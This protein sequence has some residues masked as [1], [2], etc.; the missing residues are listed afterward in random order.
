MSILKENKQL[1]I[2][3]IAN[4]YGG[5]EVYTNLIKSLDHLGVKQTIFVPLNPKNQNRIGNHMV[6]FSV[7]GSSIIYSTILKTYHRYFYT[8]KISKITK[9]IEKKIDLSRVDLIHAGLF[10]S[11]GAVA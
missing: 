2:L 10:C 7:S 1:H 11:D 9:E 6:P 8:A 4:S 5:T 3:H